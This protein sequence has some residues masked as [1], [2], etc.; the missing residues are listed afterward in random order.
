MGGAVRPP[1]SAADATASSRADQAALETLRLRLTPWTPAQLLAMMDSVERFES[2]SG[3]P[4]AEGLR[5]LFVSG[6][7]SPAWVEQLRAAPGSDPWTLGFAVVHRDDGRVIGSA[8]FKGPPG[9]DGSTEIAYGIAP[10][11][12]GRGFATEAARALVAFALERVDVT[13]I[14]A[15]TLPE[16]GAS[17]HVL[18]K[19]GFQHVGEV[20]DPEDGRVWRW[21]RAVG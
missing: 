5:E 14:R 9:E 4:L 11:Y 20:I 2:E 21:E 15:H 17:G 8:G 1:A 6:E 12:Q 3:L 13:S 7:V 19:C 10:T 18:A 16:N